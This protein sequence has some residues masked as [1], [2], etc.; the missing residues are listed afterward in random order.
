MIAP[1]NNLRHNQMCINFHQYKGFYVEPA[2]WL[3]EC[4]IGWDN[5]GQWQHISKDGVIDALWVN[6]HKYRVFRGSKAAH[7]YIDKHLCGPSA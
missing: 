3:S 2:G 6:R 7:N 1:H 5:Q 4:I